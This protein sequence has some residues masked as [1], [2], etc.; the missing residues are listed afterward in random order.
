VVVGDAVWIGACR[1]AGWSLSWIQKLD[2]PKLIRSEG[3]VLF[4]SCD[5]AMLERMT[6]FSKG[7]VCGFEMNCVES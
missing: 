3:E 5:V 7:I 6:V 4:H 1:L 2:E